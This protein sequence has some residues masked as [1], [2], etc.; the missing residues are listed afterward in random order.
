MEAGWK[1]L[2]KAIITNSMQSMS[3][4]NFDLTRYMQEDE[5]FGAFWELIYE[6]FEL[7]KQM[8]LKISGQS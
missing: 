5:K 8:V 1:D 6:E 7:T 2:S 4:S 3:K